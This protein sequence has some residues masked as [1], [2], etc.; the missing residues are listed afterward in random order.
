MRQEAVVDGKSSRIAYR[1]LRKLNNATFLAQVKTLI[2]LIRTLLRKGGNKDRPAESYSKYASAR[3][4][5]VR[6]SVV[7]PQDDAANSIIT[8]WRGVHEPYKKYNTCALATLY[9]YHRR[10]AHRRGVTTCTPSSRDFHPSYATNCTLERAW[11]W[12]GGSRTIRRSRMKTFRYMLPL[13]FKSQ[14]SKVPSRGILI[15]SL[16]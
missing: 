14:S 9:V 11:N 15:D 16:V 10:P 6:R 3:W 5:R 7:H 1:T 8:I 13:A 4:Y 12:D 2:S